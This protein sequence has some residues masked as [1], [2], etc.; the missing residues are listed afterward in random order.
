MTAQPLIH[1]DDF[2]LSLV[3]LERYPIEDL[4][5]G[6]GA[7]FLAACQ[8][9]MEQVGWCSFADFIKPE[10]LAALAAEANNLLPE[11]EELVIKRNIYQGAANADLAD[12]NPASKEY[13]HR[14]LQL[15]DDQLA[16]DTLIKQLYK[17][18]I[19][20]DFIRQVQKKPTLYRCEDEFQALNIVALEPGS[21]HAWHY[22][23]TECTVTLLLQPAEQ[24]GEFTF[25]ANSRTDDDE[26]HEAV[27][28]LLSGDTSKA[29]TLSRGAGTLTLF[30]GGYS[31]HGV[32]EI[33]G[34]KPRISAILTYAEEPG[35]VID[36]DINIRIY[37]PRA[38]K[39][40]ES[41]QG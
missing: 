39:I 20:T 29:N 26:D 25:L 28:R 40:I 31:L 3:D 37:G 38:Q 2:I 35:V 33:E 9:Q 18:D 10:R 30:R 13:T 41:R 8:Q 11:A 22:D 5:Q 17:S 7:E 21:W 27:A 19:L 6:A 15:A 24:G 1:S 36:D 14:A 32:T 4:T 16:E 34:S 12:D 23:T